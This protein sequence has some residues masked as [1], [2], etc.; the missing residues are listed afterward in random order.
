MTNSFAKAVN[1]RFK[2]IR[3]NNWAET[4]KLKILIINNINDTVVY[5]KK[6]ME[7]HKRLKN[8]EIIEF[9]ETKH[10]IF[11]E[12][13]KFQKKLWNKIDNFLKTN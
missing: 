6:I 3:S 13:E 8:S 4:I 10:E 1:R 5:S 11:M 9:N 7:M 12:K 2:K